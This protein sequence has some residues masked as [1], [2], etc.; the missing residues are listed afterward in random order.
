M[1]TAAKALDQHRGVMARLEDA[2]AVATTTLQDAIRVNR[3]ALIKFALDEAKEVPHINTQR[4]PQTQHE[5]VWSRFVEETNSA[6]IGLGL[7]LGLRGEDSPLPSLSEAKQ[8]AEAA[9]AHHADTYSQLSATNGK[10]GGLVR[11]VKK[12]ETIRALEASFAVWRG[13]EDMP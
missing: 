4:T 10:L 11:E 1:G 6:R 2:L 13:L 3:A 5:V 8:M 12:Q 9:H 7:G